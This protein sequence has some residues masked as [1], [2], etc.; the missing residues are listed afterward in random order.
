MARRSGSKIGWKMGLVYIV[1][2]L[3]I[4]SYWSMAAGY[5]K[6]HGLPPGTEHNV[7]WTWDFFVFYWKALAVLLHEWVNK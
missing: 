2:F 4:G 3:F 7:M 6:V 1:L 5:A